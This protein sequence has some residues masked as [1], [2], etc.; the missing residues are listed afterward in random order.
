LVFP[1]GISA[2]RNSIITSI[3]FTASTANPGRVYCAAFATGSV[4]QSSVTATLVVT[5]GFGV[6]YGVGA[7][8]ALLTVSG[9]K[10]VTD[11]D[12]Y[13]AAVTSAGVQSVSADVQSSKLTVTTACCKLLTYTNS[14]SYVYGS[15]SKYTSTSPAAQYVFSY[16]LSSNPA[17]S[18]TITPVVYNSF[19][20]I[21]SS[22]ELSAV[23][24]S[25]NFTSASTSLTGTYV[26]FGSALVSGSYFVTLTPSGTNVA[27]F[28]PTIS[29]AVSVLSSDS[30]A[31]TPP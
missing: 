18:V 23:P 31:P 4:L 12:L 29:A 20:D 11:Y 30:I 2:T 19:G 8:Q 6:G 15:L 10:S 1:V 26:L 14:P 9:L 28:S 13:C 25:T 3:T 16:T 21:V 22:A 24:A 27:Q 5:S 17:T 7:T